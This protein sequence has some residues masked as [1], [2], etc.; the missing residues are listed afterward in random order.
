LVQKEYTVEEENAEEFNDKMIADIKDTYNKIKL[1]SGVE[2]PERLNLEKVNQEI[3]KSDRDFTKSVDI[4]LVMNLLESV[5]NP[6]STPNPELVRDVVKRINGF[7]GNFIS[8]NSD[9]KLGEYFSDLSKAV[10]KKRKKGQSFTVISVITDDP[11]LL[12]KT[13]DLVQ[14]A[15]CQNYRSGSQIQSLPSYAIDGNIKL[16]LSY[17]VKTGRLRHSFGGEDFYFEP[18]AQ[19]LTSGEKK[20]IELGY[21]MRRQLLRVGSSGSDAINVTEPAYAQSHPEIESEIKEQQAALIKAF[22]EE[23]GILNGKSG[24]VVFPESRNPNGTYTDVGG[25]QKIGEYSVQSA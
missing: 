7:R 22:C 24:T 5:I 6:T 20:P 10:N 1:I 25:G 21:A 19:T 4:Q 18:S 12:L 23:C 11:I 9:S 3:A 16:V 15:S 8:P 14:S 2:N 13:G 17:V